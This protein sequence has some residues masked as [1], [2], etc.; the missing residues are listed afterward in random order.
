M[1]YVVRKAGSNLSEKDVME[2]VGKQVAPYKKIRRV[3]FIASVPKNPSG[4]ILRKDL[5]QLAT[6][7]SSSKLWLLQINLEPA[8]AC[9]RQWRDPWNN[10]GFSLCIPARAIFNNSYDML[11]HVIFAF[12]PNMRY[13]HIQSAHLCGFVGTWK[14]LSTF[15]FFKPLTLARC[16]RQAHSAYACMSCLV[17]KLNEDQVGWLIL[18]RQSNLLP[19]LWAFSLKIYWIQTNQVA[20]L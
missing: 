9:D 1:A 17:L 12:F 10:M 2:F 19:G 13:I 16:A 20:Q 18:A 5:I 6:S 3:A 11:C 14:I 15:F 7:S 8:F 4:K